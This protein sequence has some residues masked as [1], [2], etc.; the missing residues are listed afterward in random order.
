M[1]SQGPSLSL[2]V[3]RGQGS[4]TSRCARL[5]KRDFEENAHGNRNLKEFHTRE[6]QS[7]GNCP[8]ETQSQGIPPSRSAILWNLPTGNV[9]PGNGAHAKPH[10]AGS[11][12]CHPGERTSEVSV[13]IGT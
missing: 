12:F 8:R 5:P 2:R 13:R 1:F 6:T 11:V 9:I 7:R 4:P 10:P 3:S